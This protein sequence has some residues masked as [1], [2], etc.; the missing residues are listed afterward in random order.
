[1]VV[2]GHH[3]S[4]ERM[5]P[6]AEALNNFGPVYMPDLPGFGGMNSL[7]R[8]GE[9]ADFDTMADYLA[10]V[11]KLYYKN[12]RFTLVGFSVGFEIATRL[13]QKYP[14]I[15]ERVDLVVSVSGFLRPSDFKIPAGYYRFLK[16]SS[17]IFS[18]KYPAKFF[19]ITAL[20]RPLLTLVYQRTKHAKH[21]LEGVLGEDFKLMR[22]FEVKLWQIN[23]VRTYMKIAREMFTKDLT[24][25]KVDRPAAIV[26]FGDGDQYF[27]PAASEASIRRVYEKAQLY[28]A[29]LDRHMPSVL[30]SKEEA[31]RMLPK[32]LQRRLSRPP[33]R[34]KRR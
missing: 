17:W 6:L 18:R 28:R 21:K 9:S 19:R 8:I 13:L 12:R 4:L 16:L 34:P 29:D 10:A 24:N 27:D 14:D 7:Y 11:I 33:Y 23:D 30:S 31:L 26:S 22:R 25:Q 32:D 3:T 5:L 2:Y 15:A 20:N 1:M